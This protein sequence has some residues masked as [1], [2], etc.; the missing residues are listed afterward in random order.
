MLNELVQRY[1]NENIRT[2][3]NLQEAAEK[4]LDCIK[5]AERKINLKEESQEYWIQ[6]FDVRNDR[7]DHDIEITQRAK[8]RLKRSYESLL[9]EMYQ[10]VK[11]L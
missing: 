6:M 7:Y 10:N 11:T 4:L 8:K 5:Y 9:M 2:Q 1:S 3:E